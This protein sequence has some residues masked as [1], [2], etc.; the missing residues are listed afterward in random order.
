MRVLAKWVNFYLSKQVAYWKE[1]VKIEELQ[2][3]SQLQVVSHKQKL[4]VTKIYRTADQD[5]V[6][7]F[8]ESHAMEKPSTFPSVVP[9]SLGQVLLLQ[10]TAQ[11][12]PHQAGSVSWCQ[13]CRAVDRSLKTRLAKSTSLQ[14]AVAIIT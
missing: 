2:P 4:S 1:N 14:T 13:G 6:F 8:I 9:T 11:V 12:F 3:A 10:C 5:Q 7:S